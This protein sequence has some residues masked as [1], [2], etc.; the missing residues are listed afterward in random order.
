[1]YFKTNKDGRTGGHGKF[2]YHLMSY[3]FHRSL[4]H[5]RGKYN[6][7]AKSDVDLF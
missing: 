7:T 1:M 2:P 3:L 4:S 6:P 5:K